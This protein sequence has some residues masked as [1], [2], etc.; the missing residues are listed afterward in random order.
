MPSGFKRI[1]HYGLLG[2]AK[3]A[4]Y[5]AAARKA[6]SV[7]TPQAT[8]AESFDAFMRRVAHIEWTRCPY[9]SSGHFICIEVIMAL[10]SRS[11]RPHG[12]P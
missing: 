2:P 1:R 8:V 10:K 6:L 7:L 4:A 11:S 12:P 3:K 9:C 5:L